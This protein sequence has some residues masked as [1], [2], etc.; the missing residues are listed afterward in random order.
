MAD[1]D[2]KKLGTARSEGL[3]WKEMLEKDSRPAPD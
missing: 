2:P 3:S 1:I